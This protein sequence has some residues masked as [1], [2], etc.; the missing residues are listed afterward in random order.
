[1]CLLALSL[2]S[3][4][5]LALEYLLPPPDIDLIGRVREALV[6]EQ[7]TLLDV[8]R[9]YDIGQ[10]EIL[11]ANKKT[12]RW[13][14]NVAETVLLPTR[15]ILPRGDRRGIVIN[16]SEMRLYYFPA[17][18]MGRH[19]IVVTH[20]ISVGRMDWLTPLGKTRIVAKVR[21]PSW[22]PPESIRLEAAKRGEPLPEAIPP[23]PGNPLGRFALRLALPG[24]LIHSTNKPYGVGMRVT[25]GCIRMYP[26]DIEPLFDDVAVDTP[27]QIVD[28]PIKLGWLADTLYIEVHPPLEEAGVDDKALLRMALDLVHAEHWLR[29]IQIKGAALR[30]AVQERTGIPIPIGEALPDRARRKGD[31]MADPAYAVTE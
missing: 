25:H 23:G 29:P 19:T 13:L 14:P 31:A 30:K 8:A 10:E 1:M 21:D 17:D 15:Y 18:Y 20:P 12:D 24:Y 22:H 11:L 27:V 7:D 6:E 2:N 26:E 4:P 16:V 9:R 5:L 3:T 28:Q